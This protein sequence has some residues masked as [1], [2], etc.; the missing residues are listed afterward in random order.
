M[1]NKFQ[2]ELSLETIPRSSHYVGSLSFRDE[3]Y[4]VQC[5]GRENGLRVMM[6]RTSGRKPDSKAR[7]SFIPNR[8]NRH[9]PKRSDCELIDQLPDKLS[10]M[11][12]SLRGVSIKISK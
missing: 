7:E 12:P 9:S 1:K 5:H 8:V 2:A 11:H 4:A 3:E 10:R 6:A